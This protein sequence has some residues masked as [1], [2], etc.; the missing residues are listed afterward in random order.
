[1]MKKFITLLM[2]GALILNAPIVT[3]AIPSE[4]N[5]ERII[6]DGEITY[7]ELKEIIVQNFLYTYD[8]AKHYQSIQ[9]AE[10]MYENGS[11]RQLQLVIEKADKRLNEVQGPGTD[12]QI[13]E[14]LNMQMDLM[15]A[16]QRLITK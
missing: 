8:I 7:F 6:N 1:M 10:D 2:A 13:I 3:M 16:M 14:C 11:F 5:S 9:E 4:V 12:L 15:L